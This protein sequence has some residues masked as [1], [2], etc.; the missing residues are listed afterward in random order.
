MEKKLCNNSFELL[1]ELKTNLK[2]SLNFEFYV[3]KLS[4]TMRHL[5]LFSV[6]LHF[7]RCFRSCDKM[8]MDIIIDER[9]FEES[10]RV[11]VQGYGLLDLD[12]NE[13][14]VNYPKWPFENEQCDYCEEFQKAIDLL[15]DF[16]SVLVRMYINFV[17]T[18]LMELDWTLRDEKIVIE[19]VDKSASDIMYDFFGETN[20]LHFYH[21][22]FLLFCNLKRKQPMK[23]ISHV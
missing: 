16:T 6:C 13:T 8:F 3:F 18:C 15:L 9:D 22:L 21:F 19:T 20:Y 1:N 5:S 11:M 4:R 14:R 23:T 12:I 2:M 17:R 7:L 10:F